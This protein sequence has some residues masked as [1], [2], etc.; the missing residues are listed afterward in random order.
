MMVRTLL[1]TCRL[2]D[3]TGGR[4]VEN[5]TVVVTGDRITWCGE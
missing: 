3:G 4:V 2:I 5:A 1:T